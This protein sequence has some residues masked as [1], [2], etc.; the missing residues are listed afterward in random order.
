MA[1]CQAKNENWR[2]CLAYALDALKIDEKNRKAKYREA[3]ARAGLGEID[4]ARSILLALDK[5]EPDN[6]FRQLL[7]KLKKDEAAREKKSAAGMRGFLAKGAGK[8]ADVAPVDHN[9][10]AYDEAARLAALKDDFVRAHSP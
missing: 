5:E 2:K 7:T 1:A 10:D 4:K 8:I 6:S 9:P 3:Q